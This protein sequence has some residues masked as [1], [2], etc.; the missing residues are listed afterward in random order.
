MS[1]QRV[2]IVEDEA[3]V[4]QFIKQG[5]EEHGFE[6]DIAYDGECGRKLALSKKYEV[7]ILD[8]ILPRMNG[9]ELCEA[10]RRADKDTRILMLTALGTLNDKLDGF[11]AGADDYLVK[12]FDFPE[13]LARI[14]SLVKRI[15]HGEEEAAPASHIL[16]VADLEMNTHSKTVTRAGKQITLTAKEFA[17]LELLLSNRN[18]VLSKPEIAE[19][20]WSITFDSGTNVIEVYINFLRNKIDKG[21]PVKLI[22]TMVGMGYVLKEP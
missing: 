6:V 11:K 20:V 8:V 14:R 21:F 2:L 13:L 3:G 18:R 9:L 12:P 16:Q 19:K 10:I 17:L 1:G 4:L 7:I 22:H 15:G 5:L